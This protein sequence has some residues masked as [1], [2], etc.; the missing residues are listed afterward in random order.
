MARFSS[1]FLFGSKK[2]TDID[3]GATILPL[4]S[5]KVNEKLDQPT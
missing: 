5:V 1:L 2:L 3:P 4:L